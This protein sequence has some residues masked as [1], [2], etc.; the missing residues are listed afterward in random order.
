MGGIILYVAVRK[1]AQSSINKTT[2][3][4]PAIDERHVDRGL[5]SPARTTSDNGITLKRISATITNTAINLRLG[6]AIFLT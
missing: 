3:R 1:T 6:I 5:V 4:S 2:S